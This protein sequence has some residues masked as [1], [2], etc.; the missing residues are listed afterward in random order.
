MEENKE[1]SVLSEQALLNAQSKKDF[2]EEQFTK[3][4]NLYYA[5]LFKQALKSRSD[6]KAS[7][8]KQEAVLICLLGMF[9][10]QSLG[11]DFHQIKNTDD[12][13]GLIHEATGL[14]KIKTWLKNEK[15]DAEKILK[16]SGIASLYEELL[17]LVFNFRTK[18]MIQSLDCFRKN[19]LEMFDW[20]KLVKILNTNNIHSGNFEKFISEF[21][22]FFVWDKE[23][24]YNMFIMGIT[25][26]ANSSL[27]SLKDLIN[28][29]HKIQQPN[30]FKDFENKLNSSLSGDDVALTIFKDSSF[31]RIVKNILQPKNQNIV[32]FLRKVNLSKSDFYITKDLVKIIDQSLGHIKN[33]IQK[34][35]EIGSKKDSF[36]TVKKHVSAFTARYRAEDV[37]RIVLERPYL[38]TWFSYEEMMRIAVIDLK[39]ENQ[40]QNKLEAE[41]GLSPEMIEI[42][43]LLNTKEPIGEILYKLMRDKKILSFQ[44]SFFLENRKQRLLLPLTSVQNHNFLKEFMAIVARD[45]TYKQFSIWLEEIE[46]KNAEVVLDSIPI[47]RLALHLFL[48]PEGKVSKNVLKRLTK[49]SWFQYLTP[50]MIGSIKK[51]V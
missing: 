28:F 14:E 45:I 8:L 23:K 7:A 27:F 25:I 51:M 33:K 15:K 44:F 30:W 10:A 35:K 5:L 43:G 19:V 4:A 13:I 12:L 37:H 24:L 32:Y 26:D 40:L 20:L 29:C 39:N 36:K 50:E 38:A 6:V 16:T 49:E 3:L 46:K 1:L 18:E 11:K 41:Y 31:N 42:F 34:E 22:R 9:S 2:P 48:Q 21:Q 17:K 47:S